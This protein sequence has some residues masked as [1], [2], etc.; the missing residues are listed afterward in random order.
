MHMYNWKNKRRSRIFVANFK[1]NQGS[2]FTEFMQ[3]PTFSNIVLVVT[4]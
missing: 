2:V 3:S 1:A 4:G